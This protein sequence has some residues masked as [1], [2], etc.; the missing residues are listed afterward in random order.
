MFPHM[1]LTR[2]LCLSMIATAVPTGVLLWH[3]SGATVGLFVAACQLYAG[4]FGAF[5]L[6]RLVERA[7]REKRNSDE[8]HTDHDR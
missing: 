7:A 2:H 1:R 4:V 3:E 6:P 5:V 8:M